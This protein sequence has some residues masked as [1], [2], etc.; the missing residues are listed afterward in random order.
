MCVRAH[1]E[2]HASFTLST[3]IAG[4]ELKRKGCFPCPGFMGQRALPHRGELGRFF[5]EALGLL[6]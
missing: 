5:T 2:M 4:T 6:F 3:P 1:T